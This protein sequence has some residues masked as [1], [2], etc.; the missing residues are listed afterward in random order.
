MPVDYCNFL[1]SNFSTDRC[2]TNGGTN[3][4]QWV[5]QRGQFDTGETVNGTTGALS[6]FNLKENEL[7]IKAIGRAKKGSGASA[8]TQNENGTTEVEQTVISEYKYSNEKQGKAIMSFI[9]A[10]GKVIFQRT[11]SGQIRVYFWEFGSETGSADD[12][13]GTLIGDDSNVVKVTTK[14]KEQELPRFFEA[15]IGTSG[16][17]QLQA[18]IDYL[19]ELVK[20]D[21]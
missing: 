8:V 5:F 14:G 13:T 16:K 12:G 7:G 1:T 2:A 15:T 11:N 10:D 20:A 21:A 4:E 9:R 17:T 18:S 19:N 3:G 6:S